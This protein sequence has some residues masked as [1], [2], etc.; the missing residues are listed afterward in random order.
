MT[1]NPEAA[2]LCWGSELDRR[3]YRRKLRSSLEDTLDVLADLFGMRRKIHQHT[4]LGN[5]NMVER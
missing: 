3:L 1:V 4:E 2:A 5:T